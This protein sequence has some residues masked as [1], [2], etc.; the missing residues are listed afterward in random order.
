M[1]SLYPQPGGHYWVDV[2]CS[3]GKRR[4]IR[5]GKVSLADAEEFKRRLAILERCFD[6]GQA[7]DS[8]TT[9]WLHSLDSKAFDR[10]V[11]TGLTAVDAKAPRA[12]D[13]SID[14]LIK[15]WLSTLDVEANTLRNYNDA[16][17]NL[18]TYFGP[19]RSVPTILP[20][21]ADKF[22]AWL[23]VSG[24]QQLISK[25]LARST[26]S[27][28]CETIREVFWFAV[29]LKWIDINP[30]EHIRRGGEWNEERN[31]YVT[32]ELADHLIAKC[33]DVELAGMIALSRYATCRGRS[34]L[35]PLGWSNYDV[36]AER[37]LIRSPKTKRHPGGSARVIPFEAIP[38]AITAI[39]KLWDAAP[40]K[41]E[42]MFPRLSEL[43][44]SA[45]TEKLE[46]LC[47]T[48]GIPLWPKPW[49]NLRASCETDWQLAGR[50]IFETATWMGHAPEVALRHYNRIAKERVADLPEVLQ[51]KH[52]VDTRSTDRS[53]QVESRED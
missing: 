34:E 50:S 31:Y 18:R 1:A 43:K 6:Q 12:A 5:L 16:L 40:E 22:K 2:K 25:P 45:V 30:F 49:I 3:N 46:R 13:Q 19:D 8:V 10:I 4:P 47:R 51:P 26:V 15:E 23:R 20:A 53:S 44:W 33:D 37:L 14:L 28:R 42:A 41:T 21:E 38:K 35:Y 17:G 36:E 29:R 48:E 39:G 9:A 7:V 24:R 52:G 11:R 27:R 32:P